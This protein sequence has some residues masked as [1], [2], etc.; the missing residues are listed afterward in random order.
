VHSIR[1]RLT[2]AY[3]LALTVTLVAF[4]SILYV[5]TRQSSLRNSD[6]RLQERLQLEAEL[7]SRY[8]T[9][10]HDVLG[11]IVSHDVPPTLE[12]AIAP[13]FDSF[14]D[15]L[16][17][18]DTLGRVLYA[19]DSASAL[20]IGSFERLRA[21]LTPASPAPRTGAYTFD[22]LAGPSRYL[23]LPI[24]G[25]GPEVG[26]VLVAAPSAV[27]L[28]EP[29]ALL[30]SMLVIAPLILLASLLVGYWVAG[31]NLQP[32]GEMVRELE[33]ITDGTGLHRRLAVE[34][35]GDEVARLGTAA[36]R[37]FERLE[38][39]FAALHRFT[40]EASPYAK[41]LRKDMQFNHIS[42]GD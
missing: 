40:A 9:R 39:S 10:S 42:T 18:A 20:P 28:V 19:S 22:P 2:L 35:D 34:R 25:A 17:L 30:S 41:M 37:M 32:L 14:R 1:W 36:N 7:A 27:S 16:I 12:P 6:L 11:R 33:A 29:A 8:L 3:A 15:Y 5:S 21:P 4:G 13:Y 31:R 26:A 24:T 23:V 38:R